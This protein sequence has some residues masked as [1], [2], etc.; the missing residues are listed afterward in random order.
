MVVMSCDV[1]QG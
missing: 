1:E